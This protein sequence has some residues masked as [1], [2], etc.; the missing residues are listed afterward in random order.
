MAQGGWVDGLC[1]ELEDQT[2]MFVSW[3]LF[4]DTKPHVTYLPV[5]LEGK[6]DYLLFSL[7]TFLSVS[8]IGLSEYILLCSLT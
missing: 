8:R 2:C 5:L 4:Y 7:L 6:G 1:T 3:S